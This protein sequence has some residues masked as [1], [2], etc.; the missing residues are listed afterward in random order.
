[1]KKVLLDGNYSITKQWY[2]GGAQRTSTKTAQIWEI[3]KDG[4]K[5]GRVMGSSQLANL[6]MKY[7]SKPGSSLT[8]WDKLVVK[9]K[10]VSAIRKAIK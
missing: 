2:F 8:G 7:F 4:I 3:F 9:H 5:V 6:A 1:M 10:T